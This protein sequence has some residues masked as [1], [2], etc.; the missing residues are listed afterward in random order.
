MSAAQA[1]SERHHCRSSLRRK[2]KITKLE[3]MQTREN[4]CITIACD[5][6]CE[7]CKHVLSL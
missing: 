1:T 6:I 7:I 2:D 3:N 5:S 4:V